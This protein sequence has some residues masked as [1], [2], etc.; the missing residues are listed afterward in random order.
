MLKPVFRY[1]CYFLSSKYI[2]IISLR[3]LCTISGSW[4]SATPP[5][6]SCE[7]HSHHPTSQILVFVVV[8]LFDNLLSL[9]WSI[10]STSGCGAMHCSMAKLPGGSCS[11][12]NWLSLP[13][14]PSTAHDSHTV[15]GE[16][17]CTPSHCI[18]ACWL[19][20]PCAVSCSWC[21]FVGAMVLS[22][23]EDT[24][25]L[26]VS[27]VS[28]SYSVLTPRPPPSVVVPE[29]RES[30]DIDIC[31]WALLKHLFSLSHNLL[32]PV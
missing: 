23:P 22:C 17:S 19:A 12:W 1:L 31:G 26:E 29:F 13:K 11:K 24:I 7:I 27:S 9:I 20:W 16:G 21:E 14:K 30:C 6:N 8:V 4:A 2:F 10:H 18:L 32:T 15:K 25:L 3:I 28:V 5:L